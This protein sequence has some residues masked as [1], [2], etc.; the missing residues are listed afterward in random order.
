M[1]FWSGIASLIPG[2]SQIQDYMNQEDEKKYDRKQ[3]QITRDRE[4]NAVQRRVNDL[5]LAGLSPTLAA[6]SAASS[7]TSGPS[8]VPQGVDFFTQ[9]QQVMALMQGAANVTNTHASTA[10][11]ISNTATNNYN[12]VWAKKRGLTTHDNSSDIDYVVGEGKLYT[13]LSKEVAVSA[14]QHLKE[15]ASGMH[16]KLGNGWND[17]DRKKKMH[18]DMN[19][20]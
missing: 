18:R 19:R 13:Q 20:Y 1:G 9:A 14:Y 15:M 17:V 16:I 10:N 4:D 6:G 11:T 8:A 7:S 2:V 12:T 5:K 3:A